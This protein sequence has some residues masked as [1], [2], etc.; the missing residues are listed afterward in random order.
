MFNDS[1][2]N[3]YSIE[4]GVLLLINYLY[5]LPNIE[6]KFI[7]IISHTV[8]IFCL[9]LSHLCLKIEVKSLKEI[10]LPVKLSFYVL[11]DVISYHHCSQRRLCLIFR[12]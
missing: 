11:H 6:S 1:D 9:I 7:V 2:S 10:S 8:Y 5:I 12:Y 4:D 3:P